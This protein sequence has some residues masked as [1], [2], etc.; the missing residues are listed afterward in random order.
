MIRKGY[1]YT[2]REDK[3]QAEEEEEI[4]ADEKEENKRIDQ[5]DDE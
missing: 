1:F 2:N 3:I 5:Y 4:D